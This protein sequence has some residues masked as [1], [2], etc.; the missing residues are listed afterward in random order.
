MPSK[1]SAALPGEVD[2]FENRGVEPGD[3]T[4]G[5][6]TVSVHVTD[7]SAQR[8]QINLMKYSGVES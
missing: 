2:L 5:Q 3:V 7:E 1:A 6:G 8:R 4:R